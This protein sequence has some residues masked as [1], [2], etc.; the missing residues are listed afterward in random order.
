[1]STAPQLWLEIT[2]KDEMPC[3]KKKIGNRKKLVKVGYFQA[4][5]VTIKLSGCNRISKACLIWVT[6][7]SINQTEFVIKIVN[8]TS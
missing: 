5:S 2:L 7:F 1:M 4:L 8:L 6:A 3:V